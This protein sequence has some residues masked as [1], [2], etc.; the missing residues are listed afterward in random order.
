MRALTDGCSSD[1]RLCPRKNTEGRLGY[2]LA[3]NQAIAV[4]PY[5]VLP[6]DLIK[7][8]RNVARANI[9]IVYDF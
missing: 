2:L 6:I 1:F 7:I 5:R 3:L 8:M 4:F 9:E